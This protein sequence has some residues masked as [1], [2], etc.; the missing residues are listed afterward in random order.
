MIY[1]SSSIFKSLFLAVS[2][3][4]MHSALNDI[5]T[6]CRNMKKHLFFLIIWYI[7]KS[8]IKVVSINTSLQNDNVMESQLHPSL[9]ADFSTCRGKTC[10]KMLALKKR[11]LQPLPF[12]SSAYLQVRQSL[13]YPSMLHQSLYLHL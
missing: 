9:A 1:L 5:Q 13:S 4:Q 8:A 6:T 7:M 2:L 3:R 11:L 10:G 12:Y